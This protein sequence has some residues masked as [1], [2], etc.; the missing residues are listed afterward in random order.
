M[1]SDN[2]EHLL[3]PW[4]E[5]TTHVTETDLAV[6]VWGRTYRFSNA[7]FPT[8]IVTAGEEVTAAPI[9]LAG[10]VDGKPLA[11]QNRGSQVFRHNN[12][13]ATVSGWQ[14]NEAIIVNTTSQIEF[15]GTMRVD[16]VVMPR[17]GA[18]P[19]LERLWLEI[20]LRAERAALYHYW[21]G[22]WGNANNS[23]GVPQAG[24]A[25]RFFPFVW[26][27]WEAGGLS[28]FSESDKGW[29]PAHAEQCVEV[30]RQGPETVLRLH[31]LDSPP[32]RLPVTFTFGLQA[33]P[34]KPWPKGFHEWRIFHGANFKMPTQPFKEG[35]P[36]TVLDRLAER[37]VKTLVFHEDWTPVQN[38]WQT[39]REA[40]LRQLVA[41]CH[42]RGIKLLLYFGYE[43]S[44]LAPEWGRC[45]DQVLQKTA[46]GD[47]AGG[48]SRQPEQRD[49][50]VCYNS[51]WQEQLAR[52]IAWALD[53]YGFDGIYL[54]GTIL[55]S[56]CANEAHGCGYRDSLGNLKVSYPIFAV[57]NLMKRLYALIHP[58][59]GLINAHQSTCC[60]TPT[61]AFCDSYWD[62]EQFM[63]GGPAG[64]MLRKLSLATFRAEFMGHNFGVPAEFLVYEKP[65]GWTFEHALAV[66][67]LHDVRVR[68]CWDTGAQLEAVSKIW[69]AMTDFGVG[70]AEWHPYWRNQ[71]FLAVQPESVKSSFYVKGRRALLVVSNLSAE[72]AVEAHLEVN[73][74]A[75]GLAT[76]LSSA[77]DAVT[78]EKVALEAGGPRL[79]LPPMRARLLVIE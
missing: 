32:P 62:G 35:R 3:A 51:P 79:D 53:R 46:T 9:R 47:Y 71:Q 75:L 14:A 33:T 48:Y 54:D 78:G 70:E 49:Y 64:D 60:V 40:E 76:R 56:P 5:V 55:P 39:T 59:G 67:L 41:E 27:G 61:L 57:R 42:K 24:L 66:S 6:C 58:R 12:T 18:S 25:L 28:W 65:P 34:V 63:G 1:H 69:Q 17:Q 16:L 45:A 36:E 2:T 74:G 8:S 44:S 38:Y 77:R 72:K 29:Q 22:C 30:V 13:Q 19:K 23:G 50:I 11:F 37:G 20:P 31:L 43:L 15:D 26:L 4:T 68:P 21:P 52:G 7:P 73:A 10:E